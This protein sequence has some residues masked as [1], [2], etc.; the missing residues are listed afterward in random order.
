M[1]WLSKTSERPQG[2][3]YMLSVSLLL[4]WILGAIVTLVVYRRGKWKNHAI[5][6]A[7]L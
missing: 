6:Q 5:V 7:D 3:F 1:V 2:N 4:T